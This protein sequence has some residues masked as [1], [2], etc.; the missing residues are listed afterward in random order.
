MTH[1]YGTPSLCTMV[2]ETTEENSRD[3]AESMDAIEEVT[4]KR[5]LSVADRISKDRLKDPN[6]PFN[7]AQATTGSTDSLDPLAFL[8]DHEDTANPG[9]N[10]E[11]DDDYRGW[12]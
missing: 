5:C 1:E 4:C 10:E 6:H 9:S 2:R 7:V 8:G 3:C 12:S 11:D